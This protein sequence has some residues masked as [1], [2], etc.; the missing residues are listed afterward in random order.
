MLLCL[1]MLPRGW[2]V[3]I[4]NTLWTF[5]LHH[6][7]DKMSSLHTRYD[8]LFRFTRTSELPRGKT[9][10]S[11]TALSQ[12][13]HVWF[14]PHNFRWRRSAKKWKVHLNESAQSELLVFWC[15]LDH[16]LR[17]ESRR[18]RTICFW[19]NVTLLPI[20]HKNTCLCRCIPYTVAFA[21]AWCAPPQV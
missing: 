8:L 9:L 17:I 14:T 5:L 6:P 1:F 12:R 4:L 7:E 18:L 20:Y 13:K 3:S 10:S 19:L 21:I 11:G 16:R 2:T 15:K